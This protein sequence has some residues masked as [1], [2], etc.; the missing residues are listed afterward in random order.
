MLQVQQ[1]MQR[2]RSV[3]Q[4][5]RHAVATLLD[6]EWQLLDQ[7]LQGHVLRYALLQLLLQGIVNV[8]VQEIESRGTFRE[9]R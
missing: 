6:E 5:Q 4:L 9:V 8:L 7:E 1:L 3:L 2:V